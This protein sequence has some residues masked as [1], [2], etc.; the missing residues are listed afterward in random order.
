MFN[1]KKKSE[2]KINSLFYNES[3]QFLMDGFL[4]FLS[5]KPIKIENILDIGAHKGVWSANSKNYFPNA[6]C[7]L[8]DPLKEMAPFL[9][10]HCLK[11]PSDQYFSVGLGSVKESKEITKYLDLEGSSFLAKDVPAAI[12]QGKETLEIT[13]INHLIDEGKIVVPDLV[14]IDVQGLELEVLK[15]ANKIL[16]KTDVFIIECNF[17]EFDLHPGMP[18][19]YEVIKFMHDHNYVLYDFAG[20]L[21]RASGSDLGQCDAVFVKRDSVLRENKQW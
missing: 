2:Q 7:S 21:R 5:L 20:F 12:S 15:G 18:E 9:K 16:G 11:Y 14:K 4:N 8:F 17:F 19:I 3:C 1:S 10:Q 13:T 6:K